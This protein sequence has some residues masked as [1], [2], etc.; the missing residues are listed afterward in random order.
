[1]K[2]T[3]EAVDMV[4]PGICKYQ[5]QDHRV[6]LR[7]QQTT[8][9]YNLRLWVLCKTGQRFPI[10]SLVISRILLQQPHGHVNTEKYSKLQS[11]HILHLFFL[12]KKGCVVHTIHSEKE[13]FRNMCYVSFYLASPVRQD[14]LS[15][16]RKKPNNSEL[17]TVCFFHK[18][19]TKQGLNTSRLHGSMF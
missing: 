2:G 19:E 12:S 15:E 11:L 13:I 16:E 1:M 7:K 3:K 9:R 17:F 8:D 18:M 5:C 10:R 6:Y 4:R 14:F